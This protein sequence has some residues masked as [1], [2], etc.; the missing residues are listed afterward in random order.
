MQTPY[1]CYNIQLRPTPQSRP[2]S[3]DRASWDEFWMAMPDVVQKIR[4]R[5]CQLGI[6]AAFFVVFVFIVPF[7]WLGA[8]YPSEYATLWFLLSFVVYLLIHR[9]FYRHLAPSNLNELKDL[10]TQFQDCFPGYAVECGYQIRR[11]LHDGGMLASGHFVYFYPH[12]SP[13]MEVIPGVMVA[14]NG[15]L[16]TE[17]FRRTLCAPRPS[18]PEYD[19]LPDGGGLLNADNTISLQDWHDFWQK[20]DVQVTKASRFFR[21]LFFGIYGSLFLVCIQSVLFL[22]IDNDVVFWVFLCAWMAVIAVQFYSMC[23]NNPGLVDQEFVKLTE[24][25]RDTFGFY[26]EYR[27]EVVDCRWGGIRPARYIFMFPSNSN[28]TNTAVQC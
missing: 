8:I 17:I 22:Y 19:Y 23:T 5:K 4:N 24:Q 27:Q 25:A 16:R 20:V 11:Q 2:A 26:V 10:C 12:P 9:I 1:H 18:L 3:V 21:L 7:A 15:Y 14:S 28:N 6:S 13:E